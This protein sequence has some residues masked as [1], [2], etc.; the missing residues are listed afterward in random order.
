MTFSTFFKKMLIIK[1]NGRK[2]FPTDTEISILEK[3]T[4]TR[5]NLL[6]G[7]LNARM[8]S[9]FTRMAAFMMDKYQIRLWMGMV[10]WFIPMKNWFMMEISGVESLKAMDSKP[11]KTAQPTKDLLEMASNMEMASIFS[12]M[13]IWSIKGSF[14]MGRWVGRVL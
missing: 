4:S 9:L 13:E 3:A 5:V 1:G 8:H 6:K 14:I 12:I 7:K 11:I 2:D 10:D